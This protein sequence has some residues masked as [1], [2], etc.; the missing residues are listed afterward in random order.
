MPKEYRLSPNAVSFLLCALGL[1]GAACLAGCAGGPA[2]GSPPVELASTRTDTAASVPAT[3]TPLPETPD[4]LAISPS[5]TATASEYQ[6]W[7]AG[8]P[9]NMEAYGMHYDPDAVPTLP[10]SSSV[11]MPIWQYDMPLQVIEG[12]PVFLSRTPPASIYSPYANLTLF[13]CIEGEHW[14]IY[15]KIGSELLAY[16]CKSLYRLSGTFADVGPVQ[17]LVGRCSYPPPDENEPR[18]DY[19]YRVGCAFRSDIAYIFFLDRELRL[20][21]TPDELRELFVPLTSPEEAVNYAQLMTGLM[22]DYQLQPQPEYLYFY[23]PVDATRVELAA[24]GYH[25]FLFHYRTC[26]CEP[27]TNSEVELLVTREGEV[28]WLGARP[29]SMTIGFSCAD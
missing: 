23:D 10:P 15:C 21:K 11:N 1:A 7:L 3:R 14:D 27:W 18:E 29:W 4:K 16:D 19:L 28:T 8:R 20:V 2:Q 17:G 25:V 13:G 22:A 12:E 5:V 26:L 9:R 24:D 6:T